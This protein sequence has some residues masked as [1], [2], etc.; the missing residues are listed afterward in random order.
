MTGEASSVNI[1]S[2]GLVILTLLV[3]QSVL[4]GEPPVIPFGEKVTGSTDIA[5]AWHTQPTERYPH[6]VLG[7]DLEAGAVVVKTRAGEILTA[8]LDVAVF[9]DNT[10]RLADIDNDG[11][12]EV[13]V[14]RSNFVSG[15][16]LEAY[17]VRDRQ[18]QI[19]HETA[20]GDMIIDP[21]PLAGMS[22]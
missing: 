8:E 9:A 5:E 20:A 2:T 7:D 13:W 6:A 14:V 22:P 10:P 17:A 12:D 3:C 15:A 19:R 16:R 1:F 18:L 4:A 21:L 11:R